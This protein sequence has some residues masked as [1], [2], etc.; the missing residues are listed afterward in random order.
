MKQIFLQQP[1]ELTQIVVRIILGMK[2]RYLF[3]SL[4]NWELTAGLLKTQYS[5]LED[6]DLARGDIRARL[7]CNPAITY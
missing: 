4:R 6:A 5:L 2:T 7:A 1:D 3:V